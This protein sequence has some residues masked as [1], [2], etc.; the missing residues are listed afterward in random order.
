MNVEPISQVGESISQRNLPRGFLPLS[1]GMDPAP[2]SEQQVVQFELED[3]MLE[4]QEASN[5]W[6]GEHHRS[7][8]P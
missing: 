3:I 1:L 5:G 7:E 6:E 4:C 2:L 8:S